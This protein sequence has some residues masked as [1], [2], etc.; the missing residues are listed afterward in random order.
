[1]RK[2][3]P[4]TRRQLALAHAGVRYRRF[5]CTGVHCECEV[6]AMEGFEIIC[7][8][9]GCRGSMKPRRR[10][11]L[12]KVI[13]LE[14]ERLKRRTRDENHSVEGPFSGIFRSQR[15]LNSTRTQR[16]HPKN[17][18][19]LESEKLKEGKAADHSPSGDGE[20]AS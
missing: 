5:Q 18:E 8:T 6:I 15:R 17:S 10:V 1:M 7:N 16:H 4:P 13:D 14:V 19:A 2:W 3:K 9:T 11:P 20:D 12:A